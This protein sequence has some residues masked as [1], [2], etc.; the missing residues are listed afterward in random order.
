MEQNYTQILQGIEQGKYA[1]VYWLEG[2]EPYFIDDISAR[3][4]KGVLQPEEKD[5]NQ[6]ILYGKD[7]DFKQ[8]VDQSRQYP[9]LAQYRVVILRE[10]QEMKDIASLATYIKQPS[11]QTILVVQHKYRKVR[12]TG[13]LGKALKEKAVVFYAKKKYDN[14][15]PP[16][17]LARGKD[18][19]LSI[20]PEAA[21]LFAE[22]IGSDLSKIETE[23][24][25][26]TVVAGKEKKVNIELVNEYIG[27]S[28]E[29]NAFEL[30]NALGKKDAAKAFIIIQYFS[31]NPKIVF[32]PA[33]IGSLT[34]FF[35]RVW[36]TQENSSAKDQQLAKLMNMNS[37]FF[38]KDYRNAARNYPRTKLIQIFQLL[39]EYDLR[40]KGVE[41]RSVTNGELF[42]E[43]IF[44]I[45]H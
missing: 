5:F 42:K 13:D 25:K 44:K 41:N 26:L 39:E 10:A 1:P 18:K 23:L 3:I 29:F 22:L 4:E 33:V 6:V 27:Q 45:L 38:I 7:V 34:N 35:A 12:K 21:T 40:I 32:P 20:S 19:N 30:N 31:S 11:S 8:V 15:V 14:E 16:W 9:M 43:L 28:K 2:E 37:S 17:I 24:D 36:I